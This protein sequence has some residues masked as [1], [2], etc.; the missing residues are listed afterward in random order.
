MVRYGGEKRKKGGREAREGGWLTKR[1]RSDGRGRVR[2]GRGRS[3]ERE[4]SVIRDSI[5]VQRKYNGV[6]KRGRRRNEA[7]RKRRHEKA[8]T[9]TL[10][11]TLA[12]CSSDGVA[13][14]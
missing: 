8:C 6:T 7:P 14:G 13:E 3:G 9:F 11:F 2:K 10:R 5:I 12:A 1:G 4:E